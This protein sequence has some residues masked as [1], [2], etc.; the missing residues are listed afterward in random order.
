[1]TINIFLLRKRDHPRFYV[2]LIPRFC[3]VINVGLGF[4]VGFGNLSS[5]HAFIVVGCVGKA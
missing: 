5:I 2:A 3:A 4:I 1:M